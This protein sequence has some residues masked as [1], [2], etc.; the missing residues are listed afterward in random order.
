MTKH[1]ERT[2]EDEVVAHLTANGWLEGRSD[3]YDRELAL[4][5]EDVLGWLEETQPTELAKLGRLH[6]GDTGKVVLKRLAEVLDK[7]GALAVLRRGFKHVSAR[8]E[9]C[10]FQPAQGLNPTTLARHAKVRCRVVRQL[11]YSLN[12]AKDSLDLAFFVNGVPVAAAELKTDFTQSVRDAITQYRQDRPPR[13]PA[14]NRDEPLLQFKR[15]ALVHFAVSTDE[16]WMTTRLEGKATRFLPFNLGNDGGAGNPTNEAGYRTSYLWERVL[17]RASLL[18][19]LANFAHLEQTPAEDAQGRTVVKEA[20]I[21]PRYHQWDAVRALVGAARAEGPG[22]SYLIQHSAGSGK[23]NSIAWLAHRLS[24]LHD[25]QDAKIF[26]SVIVVT[27][28]TVLDAQLQE[29]IYQFEHKTG[30]VA[31]IES[32]AGVKSEQL[33]KALLDRTPIIIVTLQT[34]PFALEAIRTQGSLRTRRFAVIADEAHSSQTG[35]A[36]SA[37]SK[38]LSAEQIQEGEEVSAEDVLLAEMEDRASH[39]NISFFAFTATPKAKTLLRFGRRPDSGRP[40]ADDNMPVAFHIYSMQQA[41]EEGYILDVLVNY[42]PYR[43]AFRLAHNGQEYDQSEVDQAAAMKGLMRWVRLHPYNISQKVQIIVEHFR[44]NVQRLLDGH[45]KAMVV[46]GSR[47][48]AVRYKLA[49]DAYIRQQG[50]AG[51]AALVAFSGE[52][53]DLESGPSP[54]SE[55]SMNPGLKGRDIRDAFKGDDYQ[56]LI[57]ANKYQTGFDQPL[58]CA[59]Y[60]DKRLDGITAVQTLSRLNRVAP[61]KDATYV[62]DFVN[63]PND[64]LAAFKPYYKRAELAGVT[65]PNLIHTLQAKLDDTRLYTESEIETFVKVYL[66]PKGKQAALQ[67]GLAPA[68]ERFRVR[69]REARDAKDKKGLD[70]LEIVRKDL[71]SFVRLYDFL[72]QIINYGDT[73]LEKRAMFYRLLVPLLATDRLSEEIDL[74]GVKLTHYRLKDQETRRMNL[75]EGGEDFALTPPGEVGSGESRDPQRALLAA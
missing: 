40:P 14:T 18:D 24:S 67:A 8:F 34:F 39:P 70:E 9:M 50:Y 54:F 69:W 25:A 10:Q 6:N 28:R 17:E 41:I 36:A 42:T 60:V 48:E 7:D 44:E 21:F 73:D 5:P 19:I 59:M 64:I 27:D 72:S 15:R 53:S 33:A 23:S 43:L 16:I 32:K 3:G 45:A 11:R 38:V 4:Y 22:Q 20:L 55:H 57:V 49:I 35:S 1:R 52:V 68:V 12:A 74:S 37:L 29:T 56:V 46:T 75:K 13:D 51:L 26:D 47:K 63:D 66:D 58:L 2:F 62:L 71:A 31:K 30:V 65:D 61:G